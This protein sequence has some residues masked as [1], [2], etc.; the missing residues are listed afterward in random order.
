MNRR[1]FLKG[2]AAG[3]L[4]ALFLRKGGLAF[5]YAEN[6]KLDIAIVGAGGQGAGNTGNVA[7]ENIIALCDVDDQRAQGTYQ[8]FATAKRFSD[9]RRMYDEIGEEIDAVVV[10]TPDHTHAVACVPAMQLGKHVYCEK[11]LT[12]TAIEARTMRATAVAQKVMTQMGNQGS[13]SEGCRRA[14]ELAWAGVIG[15]IKEAHIWFGGGNGPSDRPKDEPPVPPG[16]HWDLWLGP[17]HFRPFHPTYIRGGWRSWR[18]FGT[19][20]LGDFGCHSMNIPFRAL[21]LD[22]LFHPDEALGPVATTPIRVQSEASEIHPET[23]SRWVIVRYEF[24]AR[25][26][27]PPAKLTWYN[28]GP[29]PP[30][31]LLLG[32]PRPEHGCLLVGEK[33]AIFSDCPWNTRYKLLPEK[34]WEGVKLPAPTIPRSPGHHAEWIRACKGGPKPFSPFEFGSSLTEMIHL[35]IIAL[36]TGHPIEYDATNAKIL[37]CLAAS[38]LLH[39]EYRYG[40]TL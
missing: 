12:R 15:A 9:F 10:S 21:R 23:Y 17:A 35:G 28:G 3:G 33:G 32:H 4:G 6:E 1:G 37:N 20:Q 22:H 5:S 36:L 27:M 24:P 13:A 25:G 29:K 31:E 14:T 18:A 34:K 40:W 16:V 30:A 8:R 38:A 11:P 39:R 7:S 19:G 26:K 2:T